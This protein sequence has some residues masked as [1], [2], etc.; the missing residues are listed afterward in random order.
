MRPTL[1]VTGRRPPPIASQLGY[2]TGAGA[3]GRAQQWRP[4]GGIGEVAAALRHGVQDDAV[5]AQQDRVRPA[6]AQPVGE[7]AVVARLLYV[8]DPGPEPLGAGVGGTAVWT[9]SPSPKTSSRRARRPSKVT[10]DDA[11]EVARRPPPDLG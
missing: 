1:A 8:D 11:H 7:D 10:A 2:R 5:G 9:A 3:A 6:D 4:R